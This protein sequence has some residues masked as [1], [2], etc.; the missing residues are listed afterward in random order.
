MYKIETARFNHD[1]GFFEFSIVY[2]DGTI[3]GSAILNSIEN[4][5]L[6]Q[7]LNDNF[8]VFIENNTLELEVDDIIKITETDSDLSNNPEPY[9]IRHILKYESGF[10]LDIYDDN[11]DRLSLE[12]GL[13][14][15]IQ[16]SKS[17]YTT[18]YKFDTDLTGFGDM[19]EK[20]V[21]KINRKGSVLK[22]K[23]KS[24]IRSIYPMLDEFGYTFTDFF[25]F[26]G[27]FDFNYH[28][29]TYGSEG[30]SEGLL[31]VNDLVKSFNLG[32]K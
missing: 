31:D 19:L 6:V 24:D 17:N 29:E 5:M 4:L 15:K 20:K 27:T 26:K 8:G 12:D 28:I 32:K 14:G 10:L 11:G 3:N 9:Y 21:S 13:S 30:E 2:P 16:L 18:N 22:L 23:D 1:S 25:V 7:N